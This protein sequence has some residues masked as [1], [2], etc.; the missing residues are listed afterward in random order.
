MRK[1]GASA[2]PGAAPLRRATTQ[3]SPRKLLPT[4]HLKE[5][6]KGLG[7]SAATR[8]SRLRKCVLVL[9]LAN[10]EVTS[11]E[12]ATE[13]PADH[14]RPA[15]GRLCR[16]REPAPPHAASRPACPGGDAVFGEHHAQPRV[17]A[18]SRFHP[19]WTPPADPWC[20]GQRRRSRSSGRRAGV[21]R[22]ARP[23]RLPHGVPGQGAL[24]HQVDVCPTGTPECNKSQ[25]R[26]GP[27]WCGPYMGFQHVELCVLGHMHRTRPLERPPA[28]HYER[29]L[30]SRGANEEALALW[31]RRRVRVAAPP[32]HGRRRFLLRG[33]AAPG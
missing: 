9:S 4:S 3:T 17:P 7:V 20:V 12:R 24:R 23:R 19:H 28:G 15:A 2:F 32:R 10:G 1:S 6:G 21:R 31:G 11:D 30:V 22:D 8:G 13:Y 25:A 27:T 5:I 14:I 18:F 26:Y 33:T 29:W 16:L